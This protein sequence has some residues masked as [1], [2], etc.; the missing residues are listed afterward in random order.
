MT[1]G[2]SFAVLLGSSV[3][4]FFPET[5]RRELESISEVR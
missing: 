4:L 5:R 3:L 2:L 1:T